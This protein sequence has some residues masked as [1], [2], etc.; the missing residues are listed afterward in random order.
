MNKL[1]GGRNMIDNKGRVDLKNA[2]E[3]DSMPDVINDF[4]R[5]TEARLGPF[6]FDGPA[7]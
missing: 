3:L 1:P 5:A 2:K 4:T 7:P 6:V